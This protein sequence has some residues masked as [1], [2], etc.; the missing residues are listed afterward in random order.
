MEDVTELISR[1][2]QELE[3]PCFGRGDQREGARGHSGTAGF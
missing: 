1:V 2:T 3:S